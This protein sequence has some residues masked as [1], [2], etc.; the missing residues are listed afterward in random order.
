MAHEKPLVLIFGRIGR[1]CYWGGAIWQ[2]PW[3]TK[4]ISFPLA[5]RVSHFADSALPNRW[6]KSHVGME[7]KALLG[8]TPGE[9][10]S[11]AG[12]HCSPSC[13]ATVIALWEYLNFSLSSQDFAS[14]Y[15]R[16]TFFVAVWA[17]LLSVFSVCHP[18]C[19]RRVLGGDQT[20]FKKGWFGNS[21]GMSKGPSS[22][23][24]L[25][26][27]VSVLQKREALD[28]WRS[29]TCFAFAFCFPEISP[30]RWFPGLSKHIFIHA[31]KYKGIGT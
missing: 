6:E 25:L 19:Y 5:F 11:P 8:D 9:A 1:S 12:S 18:T 7:T 29:R 27:L 24:A 4:A 21:P 31:A 14:A 26:Q 30:Q 28:P 3:D 20:V 13:P 22:E 16:T 23:D 2:A 17:V 10:V 15:K